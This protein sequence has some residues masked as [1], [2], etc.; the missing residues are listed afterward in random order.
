MTKPLNSLTATLP[1][2]GTTATE[3]P[4]LSPIEYNA[5]D[6]YYTQATDQVLTL[7]FNRNSLELTELLSE[8]SSE[9]IDELGLLC[10][11][12]WRCDR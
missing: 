6:D 7:W 1:V 3:T 5:L 12:S 2:D 8:S 10:S 11:Q 9:T 4:S